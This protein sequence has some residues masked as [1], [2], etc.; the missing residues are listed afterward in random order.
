MA[1]DYTI[2]G[3][4]LKKA[5]LEKNLTQEQLAEQIDVSIAFLS[6]VE[7]GSS[8][9]NLKRLTQICNILGISEGLILNGASEDSSDYLN[10][11]FKEILENEEKILEKNETQQNVKR[12][13]DA[14]KVQMQISSPI[15]K[16]TQKKEEKNIVKKENFNIKQEE[17]IRD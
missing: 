13:I 7:R 5:R 11:D 9:I 17:N 6:R 14:Y 1:L 4:R 12:A 3:E 16:R 15:I 10:A 2:I 8:H